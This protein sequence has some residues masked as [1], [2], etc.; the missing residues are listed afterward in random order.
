MTMEI[1]IGT[2]GF[3]YSDWHAHNEKTRLPF[4]PS[5]LGSHQRL[6]FYSEIFPTVEI[7]TSFYSFPRAVVVRK[8]AKQVPKDFIFSYKIPR[9]IT[10]EKKLD[11]NEGYWEEL[12]PF[13]D[14]MLDGLYTNAGPALLQ[15]PP[16]F[17]DKYFKRLEIFL[18]YWPPDVKLAVEFRDTSWVKHPRLKMTTDLLRQYN[19]AFCIVDEP[20]LP[21]ITPITANFT[22]IRFHGHGLK[23]W[24]NYQY[25]LKELKPWVLKIKKMREYSELKEIF[26]YFNNHPAGSAPANA[27]QLATLLG[28]QLKKP[29]F[30]DMLEVRKR[31]GDAPQ[32]SLETFIGQTSINLD[33]YVSYCSNCGEIVLKDDSFCEACGSRLDQ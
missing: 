8:W 31:A 6:A 13:L 16:K 30:V 26:T 5:K 21:A 9:T 14:T 12:R 24:Y 11:F 23:P 20:L 2:S 29:E 4:Y 1:L 33:D 25:S 22:Y 3:G 7:N 28:K 32:H 27:R 17:S 18:K 19:T 15:L 10:H